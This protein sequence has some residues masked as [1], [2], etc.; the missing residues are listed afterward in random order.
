MK[1]INLI[2]G[3]HSHQPVGNFDFVFQEAY[4]KSYVPFIDVL[5]RFPEVRITL[6][7]TGP[8]WDWFLAHAPDYITR[9][10]TLVARGQVEIM[11][12]AYYEPMLCAIPERDAVAQIARMKDFCKEHLGTD[13]GGMWLAE[14]VWEPHMARVLAGAGVAYA[15]LDDS[16]FLCSGLRPEDLYG[17]YMT[18]ED[19]ET[20]RV[21]PILEK[22]RYLVPFHPVGE[23]IAYLRE[24]ATEAGD[25]CAVLHD[26]GEKFGIWPGTYHSVYEEGWL[27]DFFQ[28]L[29]DNKDWIRCTTYADY[30]KG[31]QPIGR[32]YL[33]CAS[34]QEMMTWALPAY[35]QRDLKS[36]REELSHQPEL[37]AR[38]GPFLRGGFWRN[39][40]TKYAE[41]NNMQKRMLRVS[42][43]LHA[44]R[45]TRESSP[46]L[47][48]ALRCLHQGQCNC[49]YWHGQFGGLYLNHLRTAV[50]EHLIRADNA[51]DELEGPRETVQ[52]STFDFDGD[53]QPEH[54]LESDLM[55]V[56]V[57]PHDGGTLFEVDYKPGA[58][59]ILN[60][61]TR[62][63]EPYH[64]ELVLEALTEA[65][66]GGQARSIHDHF[67]SKE[68]GLDQ[69]LFYDTYRRASL[70]DHFYDA[71]VSVEDLY[72]NTAPELSDLFQRP[73]ACT[74]RDGALELSGFGTVECGGPQP[75][76]VRKTITLSARESCIEIV[77]DIGYHGAATFA[78]LFGV[79]FSVNLLTGSAPDRY[80]HTEER[81]LNRPM[82][83][84]RGVES[85]L[86][87]FALRDGWQ[88]LEVG[89]SLSEPGEFLF[90][91]LETVSQSECGQERVHQ[92]SVV[93]AGW[94]LTLEPG[95]SISRT[96]RFYAKRMNSAD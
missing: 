20:V 40:L 41:A 87:H 15:A 29:T 23:T 73:Y 54:V 25:R 64:A 74:V 14:R 77:Y 75:V 35:R 7:Y 88:Q 31:H 67:Q 57:N 18:E 68:A 84:V 43:R 94:P 62:R 10:K 3:C 90:Y 92:G 72:R 13:P 86:R 48:E 39:F 60:T 2:L 24:R 11:G 53:G 46:L 81:D 16:H 8:L 17:S 76:E 42:K 52:A 61:L 59:N 89:L 45:Q 22:L 80:Y 71:N 95:A 79:E 58:F 30:I 27:Q 12:G 56:F 33:T 69:L 66:D 78:G 91:P 28:A 47:D 26:D 55:S 9:L 65:D 4:E 6:H 38:C 83:G 5:E 93:I 49:A 63:E 70:R 32:T 51:L 85:A 50:Y 21:F 34:Y 96:I 44:L 82:L 37:N 36:A 19:G 1:T